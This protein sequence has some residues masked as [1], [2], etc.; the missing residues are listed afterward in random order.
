MTGRVISSQMV[1]GTL[2][3]NRIGLSVAGLTEGV[4]LLKLEGQNVR[5]TRIF[6][7]SRH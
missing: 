1:Q 2:G 7:V 6:T 5:D 3:Q 4:Y